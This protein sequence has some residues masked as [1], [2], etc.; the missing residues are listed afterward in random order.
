LTVYGYIHGGGTNREAGVLLRVSSGN[1][2]ARKRIAPSVEVQD[3]LN[4]TRVFET[5]A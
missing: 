5:E 1:E 3:L 2:R 4:P